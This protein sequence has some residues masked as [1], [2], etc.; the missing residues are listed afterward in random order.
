MLMNILIFLV[1]LVGSALVAAG[2]WLVF[3]PAGYIAGGV[4]CLAWSFMAARAR[5]VRE[6]TETRKGDS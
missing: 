1:G 6:F 4:L 5:A 2:A 3:P